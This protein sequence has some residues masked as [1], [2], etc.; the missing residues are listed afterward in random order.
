MTL[1]PLNS[2]GGLGPRLVDLLRAHVDAI[3]TTYEAAAAS[4]AS[5]LVVPAAPAAR[6]ITYGEP[7]Q[8]PPAGQA[9]ITVEA[10]LEEMV[11]TASGTYSTST[12]SVVVAAYYRGQIYRQPDPSD[13]ALDPDKTIQTSGQ[14]AAQT[15]AVIAAQT[16]VSAVVPGIDGVYYCAQRR[17]GP[18]RA[19]REVFGCRVELVLNQQT[20]TGYQVIS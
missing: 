3:R 10:Q 18:A 12:Y 4:W 11:P 16:L 1:G 15:L 8:L 9:W 19:T 6:A 5:G 13:P 7:A 20:S 2:L 17:S 14:L